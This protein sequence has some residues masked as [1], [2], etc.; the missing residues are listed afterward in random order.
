MSN[1]KSCLYHW[2]LRG[3]DIIYISPIL[4][5]CLFQTNQ[6]ISTIRT[7]YFLIHTHSFYYSFL[8]WICSK[9]KRSVAILCK[10]FLFMT[11]FFI[12]NLQKFWKQKIVTCSFQCPYITYSLYIVSWYKQRLYMML[13]S[14]S[15][16]LISQVTS[17]LNIAYN[18]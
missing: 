12:H 7:I 5:L 8:L 15:I 6:Y 16:S 1:M 3:K 14:L 17:S 11:M 2:H 9:W 13:T 10:A 4:S 18:K